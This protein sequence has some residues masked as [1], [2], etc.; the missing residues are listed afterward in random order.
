[1]SS[2]STSSDAGFDTP[3]SSLHALPTGYL[4]RDF[5]YHTTSARYRGDHTPE[6]N[7][8]HDID[9]DTPEAREIAMENARRSHAI[10][11]GVDMDRK[12]SAKTKQGWARFLPRRLPRW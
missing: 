1:M 2:S 10:F 4:V 11:M 9:F 3:R 6:N 7:P 8:D 5:G 12:K